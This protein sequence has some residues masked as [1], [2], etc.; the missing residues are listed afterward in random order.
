MD[1]EGIAEPQGTR[2]IERVNNSLFAVENGVRYAINTDVITVKLKPGVKRRIS[3]NVRQL[4]SNR[5]GFIDIAVPEGVDVEDFVSQMKASGE[6]S[7]VEYNTFGEWCFLPN[8]EHTDSRQWYLNSILAE[9][10]WNITTGSANIKVAVIDS[11]VDW[12]H[13][14]LGVGTD[15]YSNID[16]SLGWNYETNSSD[17]ITT[18]GH[19]TMVAGIIGAKTN[20]SMGIAGI[21]GGNNSAGVTIIPYCIGVERPIG[22]VVDDAI[23]DAVDKGVRVIQLSMSMGYTFAVT[24]AIA[25]A[26]QNDVVV[27]C[28]AGNDYESVS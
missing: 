10:A 23:I 4:R 12:E 11:G 7:L 13:P 18:Y 14:D 9:S 28:A 6:F 5:L 19:G 22:E 3:Q 24:E 16:A 2:A 15:G 27:V 1:T 8:D 20:N 17:V 26:I 21:A 25:Y